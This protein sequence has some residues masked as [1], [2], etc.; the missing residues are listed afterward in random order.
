M[1]NKYFSSDCIIHQVGP[2]VPAANLGC[3]F[4]ASQGYAMRSCLL[5]KKKTRGWEWR[6]IAVWGGQTKAQ[7]YRGWTPSFCSSVPACLLRTS[8]QSKKVESG[9]GGKV[10]SVPST[11]L[12]L[13]Q[14][15][16]QICELCHRRRGCFSGHHLFIC[17]QC[18]ILLSFILSQQRGIPN[19]N[20]LS[21]LVLSSATQPSLPQEGCRSSDVTH[22]HMDGTQNTADTR[23]FH[24]WVHA[25]RHGFCYR[26]IKGTAQSLPWQ[27]T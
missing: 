9:P 12:V 14:A 1:G 19:R 13:H 2:T 11:H 22:S 4:Q 10:L 25:N 20:V 3:E 17:K 5:K 16:A 21:W 24:M 23:I 18:R 26:S 27:P 15:F 7:S 8:A 6:E